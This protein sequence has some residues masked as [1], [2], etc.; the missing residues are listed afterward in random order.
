MIEDV[1]IK[2]KETTIGH[3]H[4]ES[5]ITYYDVQVSTFGNWWS[6]DKKPEDMMDLDKA[7]AFRDL[8][9][10]TIKGRRQ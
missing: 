10:D 2:T 9:L 5:Y 8:I 4:D 7:L 6:L 3:Q 1:R